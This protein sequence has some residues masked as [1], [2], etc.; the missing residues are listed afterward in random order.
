MVSKD[1]EQRGK[2]AYAERTNPAAWAKLQ[3]LD[4]FREH[5]AS[6]AEQTAQTGL[7]E[8]TSPRKTTAT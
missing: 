5:V 7:Q 2:A 6:L 4:H 1:V 8:V 3:A